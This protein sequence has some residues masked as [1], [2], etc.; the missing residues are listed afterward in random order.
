MAATYLDFERPLAALDQ[1]VDALTAIRRRTP[2]E[3]RELRRLEAERRNLEQSVYDGL[4]AWERVQLARHVDRPQT[5]DYVARLCTDFFEMHGDRGFGDDAAIVAGFGSYEGHPLA[6]VGH[7]RGH[8]TQERVRRNFGMAS[9][10]GYRK[11]VRLFETAERLRVPLVT[12]V[13]TQGAYP[14]VGAEERGQAE[15][16]ARSLRTMALLRVPIVSVVIGEGGS[17]GALALGVADRLLMQEFSCYSVISPEGC[18]SILYRDRAREHVAQA[19]EAL[20]LTARDLHRFGIVDE[21]VREPVG[22]AHRHPEPAVEAVARS[23]AR[24]LAELRDVPADV[25]VAERY[26]RFRRIGG[27]VE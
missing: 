13:D 26:A 19:A 18:A 7:Q 15:A 2:D 24:H 22:T 6:V 10:E 14:G 20:R 25:L 12:F 16:I 3:T 4:S 21:L 1:R 11:A 17:G 9:P 5:L 23:V 27:H 8:S